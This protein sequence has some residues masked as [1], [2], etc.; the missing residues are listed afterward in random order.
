M[1]IKYVRIIFPFFYSLAPSG[2]APPSINITTDSSVQLYWD[3]PAQPNGIIIG[4]SVN[5]TRH[6]L[7][8]S[9]AQ[10][11]FG[12]SFYGAS[13]ASFPPNSGLT[14][15]NTVISLMFKTFQPNGVILYSMNEVQT[16]FMAIELRDGIPWFMYDA[17]SGP[18]A[19]TPVE[20]DVYNDGNWHQIT[21]R[22]A[23]KDAEI[24]IDGSSTGMGSSVGQDTFV[25][26]PNVLYIGGLAN[27]APLTTV[28]GNLN[29]N[30]TLNGHRYSGCLFAV[31]FGNPEVELNFTTILNSNPGVGY[32]NYGC[33]INQEVG[34]SFL[35]GGY[36]SMPYDAPETKSF[37][38]SLWFRTTYPSGL[39][40]FSY[41]SDSHIIVNLYESNLVVRIQGID[42]IEIVLSSASLPLSGELCN[43]QWHQFEMFK[44]SDGIIVNINDQ[45]LS[46]AIESLNISTS[47]NLFLGGVPVASEVWFAY[48]SITSKYPSGFSGC[49]RSFKMNNEIVELQEDF[50]D[51]L[52]HVRFDG[53]DVSPVDENMLCQQEVLKVSTGLERAFTDFSVIP[54]AGKYNVFIL[55]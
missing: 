44:E 46:A 53:C 36:V 34:V 43:G 48:K 49:T 18:G 27:D 28:L 47:S 12:T 1:D 4:Y 2:L 19:I 31:K 29:P 13:Y 39:L 32:P 25:G 15:F 50:G 23:G 16:D 38:M 35:G 17:G 20:D 14:G 9:P 45:S 8:L 11:D 37:S 5:R 21:V 22:R 40:M 30:A 33:P 3:S 52:E 10:R 24:S 42:S 26:N 54:F 6:S 41:S 51:T 7:H 55:S